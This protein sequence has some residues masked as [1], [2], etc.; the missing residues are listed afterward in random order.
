[1]QVISREAAKAAGLKRYYTGVPCSNG[2]LSERTVGNHDCCD[3]VAARRKLYTRKN[4]YRPGSRKAYYEENREARIQYEANKRE[5][6]PESNREKVH[7]WRISNPGKR[8]AQKVKRELAKTG[9]T[10]KWMTNEQN[11][12]IA[13]FYLQAQ[14]WTEVTGVPYHV[15]HIIPLNGENVCGLHVPW[16]LQVITADENMRK[17]NKVDGL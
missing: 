13:A 9:A 15:D 6:D 4:Q 2:H 5:N 3:C 17:S 12:Q 8:K 14:I 10:P 11:A 16:N 1:M 7:Q